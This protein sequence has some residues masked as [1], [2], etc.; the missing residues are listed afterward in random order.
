MGLN[1]HLFLFTKFLTTWQSCVVRVCVNN[2][3]LSS[4]HIIMLRM[5]V[6]H[7]ANNEEFGKLSDSTTWPEGKTWSNSKKKQHRLYKLWALYSHL[8]LFTEFLST[9]QSC[10]VRVCVNIVLNVRVCTVWTS[11]CSLI[12]TLYLSWLVFLCSLACIL[13]YLCG[14]GDV[15]IA[16]NLRS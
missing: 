5:H 15:R 7:L 13:W 4:F 9:W 2:C 8:F 14:R 11:E 6:N 12:E 1:S 3:C 10:V 16:Q